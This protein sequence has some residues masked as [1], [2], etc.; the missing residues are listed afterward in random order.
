MKTLKILS[1]HIVEPIVHIINQSIG[2]S[3]WPDALKCADITPIYK[4]K[5]RHFISNYRPISLISNIAKIFEKIIYHRILGF[6]NKSKIL[7]K[8]QYGFMKN[9]GTK[10]ALN[11]VT[12]LIYEKL[13]KRTPIAATFLDLAKAFDTVNYK[14]LLSKLYNYGIRGSAHKLITSYLQNRQQRVKVNGQ[15]S[16]HC[17]VN[18]GVPQGTILG[19]LFFIL[20]INYLLTSMPDDLIISFADD[21]V[22]F[23]TE[24]TWSSVEL[25]MNNYLSIIYKWLAINKLS[26]NVDKTVCMKFGSYVNSVPSNF[27]I[28]I[29]GCKLKRVKQCKYLGIV[30]DYR[31]TWEEHIKYLINKTKYL[32]F[33]FREFSEIMLTDTLRTIYYALFHS[34]INYGIIA[35][36]GVY[37]INQYMLQRVQNKILKLV[38]KNKLIIDKNPLNLEQLFAYES[39]IFHYEELSD[40]FIRSSS[41]T[42]NKSIPLPQRYKEVSS[43]NSCMKAISLF[44]SLPNEL[45]IISNLISRKTKLKRWILNNV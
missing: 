28:L 39:L 41:T 15:I 38:N 17:E 14:I 20:Y 33:I 22:V 32:V 8:K 31:M 45:K 16:E 12:N 5:G 27:D 37:S 19:P 7:S 40:R 21:T 9:I 42:R 36:G 25:K 2:K 4:A 35:W 34:I 24:K 18:T 23:A 43:K 10:N 13:D 3:T 1:E 29:N 44:N 6:I 26:L 30:F 11:Y